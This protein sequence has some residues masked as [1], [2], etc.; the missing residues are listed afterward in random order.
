MEIGG[1]GVG[2]AERKESKEMDGEKVKE[3]KEVRW[4]G[5]K[6]DGERGW[7]GDGEGAREIR[8]GKERWD[9]IGSLGKR[10]S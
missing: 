3:E 10:W 6:M 7:E 8:R 9:N 2:E 4:R 1:E 5:S